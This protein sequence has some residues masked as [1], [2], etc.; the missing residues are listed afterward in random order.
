MSGYRLSPR[1]KVHLDEIRS[2]YLEKQTPSGA[3]TVARELRE[4]FR[5]LGR[6]PDIGHRR[7]DLTDKTLRFWPV[8]SY[9]IV[10]RP[11]T[12]PLQIVAVL[13]GARDVAN[14]LSE[15]ASG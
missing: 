7:E 2:W 9:L 8:R 3:R 13:H 4:A 11:A 12:R 15:Q 10:Y 5:L 6:N 14:I 1:A